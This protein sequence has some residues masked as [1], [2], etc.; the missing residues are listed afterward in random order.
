MRFAQLG[1]NDA[2]TQL[3]KNRMIQESVI[4]ARA[5]FFSHAGNADYVR[6]APTATGGTNRALDAD[7]ADNTITPAFELSA[8]KI[9]GGKVQVDRAHERRGTDLPSYR[10]SELLN[11]AENAAKNFTDQFFNGAVTSTT[12]DG[13]E[14]LV[15]EKISSGVN[16]LQLLNGNDNTAKKSQQEFLQKLNELIA[17]YGPDVLYANGWIIGYLSNI[18][19]DQVTVT[20][21]EFGKPITMYAGV[22]IENPGFNA[23]GSLILPF[24]ETKGTAS[25]VC[26]SIYGVKYGERSK[27]T[28]ATNTG[29]EVVD[30][31]LVGAHWTHSCEFDACPMLL[32]PKSAAR[33]EG[34]WT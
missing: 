19:R 13:L 22:I 2:T 1:A 25:G 14:A 27:L 9:F 33:L 24:D 15:T 3:V 6:K 16:G 32:N 23:S 20:M 18:A 12:F 31:G 7:Y 26:T 28:I 30:H 10:A 29:L 21:N 5:E 4:L 17:T 11:F 34:L 8:L